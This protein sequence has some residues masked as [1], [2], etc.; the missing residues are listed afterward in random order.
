MRITSR[1][2]TAFVL[3]LPF[4]ISCAQQQSVL[5]PGKSEADQLFSKAKTYYDKGKWGKAAKLFTEF[6]FSYPFDDRIA[7]GTYLL[8]D[9]YYNNE[10]YK[11]AI[12]EYRRVTQRFSESEF[13]E[14]AELMIAESYLAASPRVALEQDDTET[15]LEAFRDFIAYHPKSE[16][17]SQA[18]EGIRRCRE[19]LA[20]KEYRA[21]EL[22][23]K[24]RKW[25]SA[26]LYADLIIEEY[27]GTSSVPKAMLL[28]GRV[29]EEQLEQPEAAIEIFRRIV[30]NYPD[31]EAAGEASK[32]LQKIGG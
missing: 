10:E 20:E 22:Y 29:L 30:E 17:I 27:A 32:L 5:K 3:M 4:V 15:A 24:L 11:L 7:E 9:S 8:A 28:K 19:K 23:Y 31:T 2:A 18:Q 12:S 1:V 26:M 16:Y 21:A 25:D 14:R 6:V 13:A